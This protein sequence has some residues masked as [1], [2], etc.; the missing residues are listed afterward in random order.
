MEEAKAE[1]EK[2][3]AELLAERADEKGAADK[4]KEN[5]RVVRGG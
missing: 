4:V 2:K 3:E 1:R 5:E